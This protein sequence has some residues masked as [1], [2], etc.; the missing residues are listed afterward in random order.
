M[1]IFKL[2]SLCNNGNWK[3]ELIEV[4]IVFLGKG[5]DVNICFVEYI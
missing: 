1:F 3:K 2:F 5:E 4:E